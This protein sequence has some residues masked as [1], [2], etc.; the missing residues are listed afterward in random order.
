MAAIPGRRHSWVPSV[1]VVNAGNDEADAR[2]HYVSER[3]GHHL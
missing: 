3:Y 2:A 1:P